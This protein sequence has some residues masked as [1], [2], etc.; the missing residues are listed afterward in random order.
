MQAT[1]MLMLISNLVL[2]ER[3]RNGLLSSLDGDQQKLEL[4]KE[5]KLKM[6]GMTIKKFQ[7][8]IQRDSGKE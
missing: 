2:T 1:L 8:S 5:R 4:L 3:R 7:Q 6:V